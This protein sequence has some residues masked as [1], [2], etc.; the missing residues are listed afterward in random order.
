M[1]VTCVRT[2]LNGKRCKNKITP[3]VYTCSVHREVPPPHSFKSKHYD[4]VFFCGDIHGDALAFLQCLRLSNAIT[5]SVP[6][7]DLLHMHHTFDQ[8]YYQTHKKVLGTDLGL[9][10]LHWREDSRDLLIFIGDIVDNYRHGKHYPHPSIHIPLSRSKP[11]VNIANM[12]MDAEIPIVR[13]LNRLKTEA[14]EAGGDVIWVMGNHDVGNVINSGAMSCSYYA[15]KDQCDPDFDFH[16]FTKSRSMV[17]RESMLQMNAVIACEVDDLLICHGGVST[18]F[19]ERLPVNI[20][21][22]T[23]IVDLYHKGVFLPQ[24]Y[25]ECAQKIDATDQDELTWFRPFESHVPWDARGLRLFVRK[26]PYEALIVAHTYLEKS[27]VYKEH[28]AM[29]HSEGYYAAP[30][31]TFDSNQMYTIPV[32]GL[33]KNQRVVGTDV[34]MSRAFNVPSTFTQETLCSL[35]IL[36]YHT[37]KGVENVEVRG[38]NHNRCTPP[39]APGSWSLSS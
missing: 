39:R 16:R 31:N 34:G 26:R 10:H 22:L 32:N 36:C 27:A 13:T 25:P 30:K 12:A 3:G 5:S 6:I 2:T 33:L 1:T 20:R 9:Q 14:M 24:K 23:S 4:N 8:T 17:I 21:N 38:V 28:G 7:E 15:S 37:S 35:S 19:I 29:T 11:P 18:T